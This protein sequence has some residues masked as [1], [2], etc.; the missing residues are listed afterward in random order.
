[1]RLKGFDP[2]AIEQKPCT[3]KDAKGTQTRLS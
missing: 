1:L 2:A 3:A